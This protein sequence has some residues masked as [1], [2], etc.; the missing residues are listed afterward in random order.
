MSQPVGGI[1]GKNIQCGFGL[2]GFIRLGH[3]S[4]KTISML[5]IS[6]SALDGV[7]LTGILI[8]LAFDLCV[9]QIFLSA[10]QRRAGKTNAPF[11]AE[12]SVTRFQ[13]YTSLML[14]IDFVFFY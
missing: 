6:V 7:P 8:H 9:C 2:G 3:D 4:I 10:A 14:P 11:T 1:H 13:T 5:S 12:R